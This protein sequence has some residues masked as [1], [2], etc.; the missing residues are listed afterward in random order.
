MA[1]DDNDIIQLFF[2]RDE[3]AI[4]ETSK[5]YGNYCSS[6]AR[7]I[8]KNWEDAEE[9]VNDTY[10][11]AW[12]V[13]PPNRP[14]MFKAFLGRITRNLAFNLYKKMNA[15]KR[16][17]GQIALILDELVECVSDKS[18]PHQEFERDEL[19]LTINSFLGKLSQEKRIMFVRRYWYSDSVADIAKRCGVSENYVSVNLNRLRKRL[20]NYLIERGF[21]L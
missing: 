4:K 15:D 9:C 5:K 19:L 17:N 18:N 11:K 14:T 3:N 21:E 10:L 16:G 2:E 13:I 12:N 8:L 20:L 6:I 1:M 7:N